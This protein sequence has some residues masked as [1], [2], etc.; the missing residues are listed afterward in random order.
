MI[1]ITLRDSQ[2]WAPTLPRQHH[3]S[4]SLRAC[5]VVYSTNGAKQYSEI[6]NLAAKMFRN[7]L[8]DTVRLIDRIRAMKE[9]PDSYKQRIHTDFDPVAGRPYMDMRSVMAARLLTLNANPRVRQWCSQKKSQLLK[10][11]LSRFDRAMINRLF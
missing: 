8:A 1:S 9:V 4:K 2:S 5:A 6:R 7:P 10:Q 11:A 3:L